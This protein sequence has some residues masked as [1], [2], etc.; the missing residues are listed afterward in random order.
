MITL[1][2]TLSPLPLRRYIIYVRA[3]RLPSPWPWTMMEEA[4]CRSCPGG[5]LAWGGGL[6][7]QIWSMGCAARGPVKATAQE[8]E[9]RSLYLLQSIH[10]H[11]AGK[12]ELFLCLFGDLGQHPSLSKC[13]LNLKQDHLQFGPVQYPGEPLKWFLSTMF[14]H[15]Y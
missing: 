6:D 7:Q 4:S 10:T 5:R 13:C 12:Q 9:A 8:R 3:R 1:G 14:I 15:A 11:L 2:R